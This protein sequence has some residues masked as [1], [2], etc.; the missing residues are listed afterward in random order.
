MAT[1]DGDGRPLSDGINTYLW[2]AQGWLCGVTTSVDG[3]HYQY[4]Y[5]AEGR[6]VTTASRGNAACDQNVT[7]LA[8]YVIDQDGRQITQVSSTQA[9]Q[10]TNVFANGEL[11]A[12]YAA[13][14]GG[15]HFALNDWLGD[16]R[17]QVSPTGPT[18]LAVD[19]TCWN[20]PFNGHFGCSGIGATDHNYTGKEHDTYTSLDLFGAREYANYS[21]R[22]LS[23]DW[24]DESDPV[25]YADLENPQTL[26]LYGYVT[27]NPLRLYDPSGHDGCCDVLPTME[28]VDAG[29]AYLEEGGAAIS[30]GTIGPVGVG[31]GL[32]FHA[33]P[34]GDPAEERYIKMM[35]N[36]G[37]QRHS[38]T[39]LAQLSDDEIETLL[40]D[41]KTSESDK[42]KLREQQKAN[43]T[44]NAAKRGGKKQKAAPVKNDPASVRA[45]QNASPASTI[46]P[47]STQDNS[48]VTT[49]QQ[50]KL[51]IPK[52]N[53]P[54]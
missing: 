37:N 1:F 20:L 24:S 22:F 28:E 9:W 6:K 47:A 40:K 38:H 34:L 43:K 25:P 49:T 8:D 30:A 52:P 54:E 26:N 11:L 13:S 27:N 42:Q 14:D 29:I 36:G 2:E 51:P 32:F 39:D 53:Q 16:K 4:I 48:T 10:H 35:G 7:T 50:D 23:P 12:T 31:L 3:D 33:T 44:R 19:L 15:L 5:D 45:R 41:P 17:V 18:Q 21:G 46:V